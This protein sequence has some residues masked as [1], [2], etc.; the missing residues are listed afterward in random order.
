LTTGEGETIKKRAMFV[1]IANA[2]TTG[3]GML[4]APGATVDDGK[5]DVCLAGEVSKATLLYQLTQ[6]FKGDHV[7]HPAVTILRTA[8]LTVDADPPQ[9]L[10]I[11]GEVIGTTPAR[12]SLLPGALP[13]KVPRK[14]AT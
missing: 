6:V 10:L 5:L 11:D 3:G 2:P 7:K 8:S 4:I 12:I 1:S 14:S 9:P 13:M